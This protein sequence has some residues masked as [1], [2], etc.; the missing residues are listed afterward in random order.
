MVG[1]NPE[2]LK[3]PLWSG[4]VQANMRRNKGSLKINLEPQ[5]IS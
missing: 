3:R 4:Y 5:H 2:I 1:P